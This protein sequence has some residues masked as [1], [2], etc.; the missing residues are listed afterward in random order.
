MRVETNLSNEMRPGYEQFFK[1][2]CGSLPTTFS[3]PCDR[4]H[5]IAL[6][7]IDGEILLFWASVKR[8][9]G[10]W[11]RA[12]QHLQIAPPDATEAAEP[13]RKLVEL[14]ITPSNCFAISV[15][16]GLLPRKA[17]KKPFAIA[18]EIPSGMLR[19]DCFK[20]S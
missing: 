11:V 15:F 2:H 9:Y 20:T 3:V 8:E 17:T 13:E 7:L 19:G 18:D 12:F 6:H 10:K 1:K 4:T 14:R 16:K 5:A